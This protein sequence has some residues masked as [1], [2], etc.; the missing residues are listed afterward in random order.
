TPT[1]VNNGTDNVI[2]GLT[3]GTYEVTIDNANENCTGDGPFQFVIDND[4]VSPDIQF[5]VTANDEYCGG[6]NQGNGELNVYVDESGTPNTTTEYSYTWY[7]GSGTGTTLAST[8]GSTVITNNNTTLTGLSNGTYTV[9]VEDLDGSNGNLNCSST[10][11]IIV[12]ESSPII[13][14]TS[15]EYSASHI[16]CN[17]LTG[18]FNVTDVRF[19]S[20][21]AASLTP[22]KPLTEFTFLYETSAGGVHGGVTGGDN[23]ED[24]SDL[25]AGDYQLTITW[26]DGTCNSSTLPFTIFDNSVAPV[27]TFTVDE[28]DTYCGTAAAVGGSGQI[29]ANGQNAAGTYTFEWFYGS[30]VGTTLA[31][32]GIPTQGTSGTNGQTATG[33]PDGTYTVR[34][35]D[36]NC[37]ATAEIVLG[38]DTPEISLDIASILDVD[39]DPNTNCYSAAG[40]EGTGAIQIL[41]VMEDGVDNGIAGYEFTWSGLSASASEN[42]VSAVRDQV[43]ILEDG[44]YTVDILNTTTGCTTTTSSSIDIVVEN[45]SIDPTVAST[46][47]TNTIC[48]AAIVGDFDGTINVTASTG[49]GTNNYTFVWTEVGVGALGAGITDATPNS[50]ADLLDEGQY[51]VVVQDQVNG[52]STTIIETIENDLAIPTLAIQDAQ[53][54]DIESCDPASTDGIVELNATD[55]TGGNLG[56]YQYEVYTVD[57]D[58][59]S[60]TADATYGTAAAYPAGGFTDRTVGLYSITA[61]DQ[62]TGCRTAGTQ[63]NVEDVSVVPQ[64]T[65]DDL[66]ADINCG[67]TGLALGAIDISVDQTVDYSWSSGETVE[68][69]ATKNSGTYTI[70]ATNTTTTCAT[71]LDINIEDETIEPVVTLITPTPQVECNEDGEI[72]I[73]TIT[74][75]QAV[76]ADHNLFNFDWGTSNLDNSIQDDATGVDQL[77][78]QTAG[79]YYATLTHIS[80]NCAMTQS[81]EVEIENEIVL[82]VIT[83]TEDDPDQNCSG[84]DD[85]G[86]LTALADGVTAGYT[87]DWFTGSTAGTAGTGNAGLTPQ[88]NEATGLNAGEFTVLV[89]APTGC[90][91]TATFTLSNTPIEPVISAIGT[92]GSTF[93]TPGNGS[94]NV[95]GISEGALTDYSYLIYTESDLSD[96]PRTSTTADIPDVSPGTYYVVAR[97]DQS[98]P[99]TNCVSP[100]VEV[101]V[102][103]LSSPP[104][105]T[106][107]NVTLQSNCDSGTP[108]GLISILADD[109][110]IGFSFSWIDEATNL[111]IST[112]QTAQMLSAGEYTVTVENDDTGCTTVKTY[113][114]VDDIQE[115]IQLSTSSSPNSNCAPGTEDGRMSVSVINPVVPGEDYDYYWFDGE[116]E[117]PDITDPLYTGNIQRG[118]VDG[119]YTVFVVEPTGG[120]M[121]EPTTVVIDD[122]TNTMDIAFEITE[123]Q[124]MTNCIGPNAILSARA[125]TGQIS[126]Y[127]FEWFEGVDNTG[128]SLGSL[129]KY[130]SLAIGD[131]HVEMYDRYTGC[132]VSKTH[133]VADSTELVTGVETTVITDRTN[134][135]IENGVA[136]A[137]VDGETFGY[138][139]EWTDAANAIIGS[140][141]TAS[142]LDEGTYNVVAKSNATGCL[143]EPVEVNIAN[144]TR[145]PVFTVEHNDAVCDFNDGLATMV[146]EVPVEVDSV[147]WNKL[148]DPLPL[149]A[150]IDGTNSNDVGND[151]SL[152]GISG[153]DYHVFLRDKNNCTY[154]QRFTIDT[155]IVIYNGVSDNGDGKNDFFYIACADLFGNNSVKIYNRTGTLVYEASRYDNGDVVFN[156]QSNTGL[157][158]GSDGLP[159]GTYFYIFDKGDGDDVVQGYLELVR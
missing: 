78:A 33:L 96:T 102:E 97:H 133:E 66:T 154:E 38:E 116:D 131:Y 19:N 70:T 25:A 32:S 156:G 114:M 31:A 120:C 130:D 53:V 91:E 153:G 109:Q 135:T 106:V 81:V 71:T 76:V 112:N 50:T 121:S 139:F 7:R 95:T 29:T 73:E 13:S 115:P 36:N 143:S 123:E 84:T 99:I 110:V 147:R 72:L 42:D 6:V 14:I 34:I 88:S 69:I 24:I 44:T 47:D 107:N 103:D 37:L 158:S 56:D 140:S 117:N 75:N 92:S 83:I 48:D 65:I 82:P 40:F 89:V 59:G 21:L 12:D 61:I 80:T 20:S 149:T 5:N 67:G 152:A 51:Q 124:S 26:D 64:I 155:E 148:I 39:V 104:I 55:I 43:T 58:D 8:M 108:N 9:V 68:D 111:E 62:S 159:V 17:Q 151:L 10:L 105:L 87:F 129:L 142:G 16:D 138:T 57:T 118:L 28:V 79:T 15:D 27:V 54:T 94:I 141:S 157:A 150:G 63:A 90:E 113:T 132:M 46:K 100:V 146:F 101:N 98:A 77:T 145:E 3:A 49:S 122:I 2:A 127:R 60:L 4:A 22:A 41:N 35:T 1:D 74:F 144:I 125:T 18:S 119:T 11:E 30:G 126:D 93:C 134:C 45:E 86:I 23:G 136:L 52:C 85:K 128:V 137:L